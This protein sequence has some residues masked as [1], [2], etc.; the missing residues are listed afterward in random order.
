[1]VPHVLPETIPKTLVPISQ[2]AS[3]QNAMPLKL[4]DSYRQ[5]TDKEGTQQVQDFAS[6]SCPSPID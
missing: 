2:L 6:G 1:M 3:D 5:Y 4:D